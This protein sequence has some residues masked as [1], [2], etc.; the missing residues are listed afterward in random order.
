MKVRDLIEELSELD[1]ELEIKVHV[2]EQ[3]MIFEIT[4]AHDHGGT[5]FISTEPEEE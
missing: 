1:Q 2:E 4:A 3:D 5:V